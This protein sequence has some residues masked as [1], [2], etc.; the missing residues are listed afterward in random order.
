MQENYSVNR[1][2]FYFWL[3]FHIRESVDWIDAGLPT[4]H[5]IQH[6]SGG[7]AFVA[8]KLD[9]Y[10]GTKRAVEFLNDVIARVI[11]T[12]QAERLAY[13]PYVE[14]RKE[15]AHIYN[16]PPVTL[17]QLAKGLDSLPSK[18]S[19]YVPKAESGKDRIFWAIKWK[20]EQMIAD[21]GEGLPISFDLLL[22]WA[23]V[24]FEDQAKDKSTLKSKCR[25]VWNWYDSRGWRKTKRISTMSRTEAGRN[26]AQSRAESAVKKLERV[27]ADH[28]DEDLRKPNGEYNIAKIARLAGL[29]RPTVMKYL[30]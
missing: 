6:T 19:A 7:G 18:W 27:L 13:R 25:N 12:L 21:Q 14:D 8:W 10:F 11:L 22:Q 29:S 17:K 4:P 1:N 2:Y 16:G 23:I 5:Y 28:E 26:A 9:G 24:N 3:H 30:K 20:V 15:S